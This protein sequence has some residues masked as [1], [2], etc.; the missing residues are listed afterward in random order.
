VTYDLV[1][2]SNYQTVK[3]GVS[4]TRATASV[5]VTSQKAQ[6]LAGLNY[7][8]TLAAGTLTDPTSISSINANM[9]IIN[10]HP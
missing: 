2:G 7:A 10:F 6:T 9:G 5:V 4:Y 8:K 3:A 1:I